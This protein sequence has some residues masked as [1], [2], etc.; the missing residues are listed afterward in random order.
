MQTAINPFPNS[1][2]AYPRDLRSGGPNLAGAGNFYDVDP[3][4]AKR[5]REYW[6]QAAAAAEKGATSM[7]PKNKILNELQARSQNGQTAPT[8]AGVP[9]A[10]R[11]VTKLAIDP[12]E[13]YPASAIKAARIEAA[14]DGRRNLRHILTNDVLAIW[15]QWNASGGKTMNWIAEHNS[16]LELN[17]S[18]VGKYLRKYREGLEA[19]ERP[20]PMP[21]PAPIEEP[22]ET[23]VPDA[24]LEAKPEIE[25]MQTAVAPF[26]VEKPESLP[27]FFDREYRPQRPSPG[28]ALAA[29][30][31]LVNSEQLRVRGSVK[32]NLEIEFGE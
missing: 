9:A 12:A 27:D 17:S 3:A 26:E 1:S 13:T 18:Q 15:H 7:E 8:V 24:D 14:K 23:A 6:Q 20:T 2:P 28:D 22:S 30:A 25:P 10:S 29:L 16:L 11:K 19:A 21:P 31:A 5:L 32:L 4:A